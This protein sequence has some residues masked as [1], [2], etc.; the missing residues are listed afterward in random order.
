MDS[1]RGQKLRSFNEPRDNAVERHLVAAN[2]GIG[3]RDKHC[4][5]AGEEQRDQKSCRWLELNVSIFHDVIFFSC[6]GFVA[7]VPGN[8]ETQTVS[9][10]F[11]KVCAALQKK[12]G[13]E[14]GTGI[15]RV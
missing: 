6:F 8:P 2:S 14:I 1:A 3:C 11:P 12:C 10:S 7:V 9:H 4:R 5:N 13:I 15:N